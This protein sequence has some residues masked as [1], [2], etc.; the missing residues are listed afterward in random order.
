MLLKGQQN[1]SNATCRFL[2]VPVKSLDKQ[3]CSVPEWSKITAATSN[4]GLSQE[5]LIFLKE[6]KLAK[7]L[8]LMMIMEIQRFLWNATFERFVYHLILTIK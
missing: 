2:W 6:N 5:I 7:Q 4:V 3:D 8:K 1:P